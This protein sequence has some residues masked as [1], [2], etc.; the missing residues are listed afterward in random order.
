MRMTTFTHFFAGITLIVLLS[1]CETTGD[2]RSGGL[3]WSETK[4]QAR[5]AGRTQEL[6][7]TRRTAQRESVK[8]TSL[9][10]QEEASKA[11]VERYQRGLVVVGEEI[12]VLKSELEA[13]P[14][15]TGS[16]HN[17]L[18]AAE[19]QRRELQADATL[20]AAE[21]EQR[22]RSLRQDVVRLRERSRLLRET[23]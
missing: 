18:Q 21:M 8:T 13:A 3:F 11:E 4:A 9:R 19:R 7:S 2:P 6:E 5:L 20:S 15:D 22:L 16:L 23:R 14:G 12:S 10:Q 1:G 17:E